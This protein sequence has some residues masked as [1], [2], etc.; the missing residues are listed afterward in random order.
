MRSS[1]TTAND[2]DTSRKMLQSD[3]ERRMSNE[4]DDSFDWLVTLLVIMSAVMLVASL[5][6]SVSQTYILK[7]LGDKDESIQQEYE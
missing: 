2:K 6:V 3:H 1:M 7:E 4:F 5:L